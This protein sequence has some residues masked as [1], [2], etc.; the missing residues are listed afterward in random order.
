MWSFTS[1][2]FFQFYE[3]DFFLNII[4]FERTYIE[5]SVLNNSTA[6]TLHNPLCFAV[7]PSFSKYLTLY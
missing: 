3:I 6:V 5:Q 1:Y 4:G 7:G 2:L